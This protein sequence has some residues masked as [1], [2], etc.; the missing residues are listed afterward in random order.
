MFKIILKFNYLTRGKLKLVDGLWN[1][2]ACTGNKFLKEINPMS[3]KGLSKEKVIR[4]N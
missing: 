2:K 4:S 1:I 3:M